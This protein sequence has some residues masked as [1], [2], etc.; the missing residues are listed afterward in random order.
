M[1]ISVEDKQSF[2]EENYYDQADYHAIREFNQ[3]GKS[4]KR[5]I[6]SKSKNQPRHQTI[7][8]QLAKRITK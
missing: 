4:N 6:R 8:S 1:Q 7:M 3:K 5:D 2:F